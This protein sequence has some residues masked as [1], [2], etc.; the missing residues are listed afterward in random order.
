MQGHP[1]TLVPG[2]YI[3][4]GPARPD[5][6]GCVSGSEDIYWGA[7]AGMLSS[8]LISHAAVRPPPPVA[9]SSPRAPLTCVWMS[10]WYWKFLSD[11]RRRVRGRSQQM[12]QC[13]TLQCT[14]TLWGGL[15]LSATRTQDM[16]VGPGAETPEVP[17]GL[18]WTGP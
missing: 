15:Y 17:V 13:D 14:V 12:R 3:A 1:G 16:A 10:S 11:S 18:G 7:A 8:G 5:T 4:M 6:L 2:A 9:A